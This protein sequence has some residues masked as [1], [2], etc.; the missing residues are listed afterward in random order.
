MSFLE[1]NGEKFSSAQHLCVENK[2]LLNARALS[3][4]TLTARA[5]SF[6]TLT[7]RALS[8]STLTARALS[9]STPTAVDNMGEI[10]MVV[11]GDS[12]LIS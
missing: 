6:S 10:M 3:F 11:L 4:S 12:L 2:S 1:A 5:L 7:A 8:F 9:F